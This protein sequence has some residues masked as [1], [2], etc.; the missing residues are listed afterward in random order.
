[1]QQRLMGLRDQACNNVRWAAVTGSR[2]G[3]PQREMV[4]GYV[5]GSRPGMTQRA[6][7]YDQACHLMA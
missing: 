6:I 5:T 2:P 1:M 3:M 4:G 7:G